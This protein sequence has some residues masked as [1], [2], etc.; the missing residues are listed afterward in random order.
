MHRLGVRA[1]E[2][3]LAELQRATEEAHLSGD[4]DTLPLGMRLLYERAAEPGRAYWGRSSVLFIELRLG[5]EL[6]G[7]GPPLRDMTEDGDR[8]LGGIRDKTPQRY[9]FGE[10]I[11]PRREVPEQ[12]ADRLD[13]HALEQL[14]RLAA[15]ARDA[16]NGEIQGGRGRLACGACAGGGRR[17][18]GDMVLRAHQCAKRRRSRSPNGPAGGSSA[19]MRST[20]NM[21]AGARSAGGGSAN[22]SGTTTLSARMRTCAAATSGT[23]MVRSKIQARIRWTHTGAGTTRASR[24]T[25]A[26]IRR[27]ASPAASSSGPSTA[28]A[29]RES[30]GSVSAERARRTTSPT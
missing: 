20:E 22:G 4:A 26:A 25:A 6:S 28:T 18:D 1:L 16:R 11:E 27:M 30:R 3:R 2:G 17:H 24:P 8:G 29:R 21:V 19:R 14:G 10:I 23:V 15:D 12:I 5:H 7:R 9:E 13:L